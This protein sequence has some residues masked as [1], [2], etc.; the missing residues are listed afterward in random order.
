MCGIAG[1]VGG[2]S[3]P[4]GLLLESL[5]DRL[6]HRGPDARGVLAIPEW[7]AALGHTRLAVLDPDRRSD[8]PF[9]SACGRWVL[10]FNG[11][12]YDYLERRERLEA[13]GHVFRTSSD[14]E[15]LLAWLIEHGSEGLAEL[16]GMFALAL[17]DRREGE[18]LLARDGMGEKPMYFAEWKDG[19]RARLAFASEIP[20]LTRLEGVDLDLDTE[21]LADWLRFL[22]TAAPRTL[23]RGIRELQPGHHALI[24]LRRPRVEVRRWYDLE[25]RA[26]QSACADPETAR[27]RFRDEFDGGLAR[28][29]R[30]DV[31]L[32]LYLSSGMDSG[33]ILGAARSLAPGR[34]LAAFTARYEGPADESAAAE[35]AA[36]GRG[37][38]FVAVACAAGNFAGTLDRSL[39]LFGQPFGNSTAIVADRI[40]GVAARTR[41]VCLL[42]DGGDELAAGYP[43]HAALALHAR[44]AAAPAPLRIALRASSG[45]LPERG[46]LAT[47]VRRLRSFAGS[48]ESDLAQAYVGW[49][50]YL[51]DAGLQR[52]LGGRPSSSLADGLVSLFRRNSSDPL[53]AAALVDFASFVP[54]NLLQAAD[55]TGMAHGLELRTPFLAPRLVE[56]ALGIPS[57]FKVERGRTKP[58]LA[59][60]LADYLPRGSDRRPKLPFNPPIAAWLRTHRR[61]LRAHLT[62]SD[63]CLRGILDARF[64]EA[65][66]RAFETGRR[67]NATWLWGLAG[68][69]AWL[70]RGDE[71]ARV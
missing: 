71:R 54:F 59:D 52:A 2:G 49:C 8:Q 43:R 3:A 25:R 69:E 63:A 22:Y 64:V 53:R 11:T 41:K 19:G 1:V 6:S 65:E 45:M 5:L 58:L 28:R 27:R 51:D 66:L 67:D 36:R 55:R 7:H 39:E 68:L 70:E 20:A 62:A 38:D 34:E 37:A 50:T 4:E 23:Y 13:R 16:D 17:L 30:S 31:P 21:A 10:S 14:T 33:A 32:G 61:A 9:V 47:R 35:E 60:A 42:G 44:L 15:V 29:L 12:I 56:T 18:L 48:L 24:D 57:V 46:A 26:G 40:A